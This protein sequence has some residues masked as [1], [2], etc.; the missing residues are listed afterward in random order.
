MD[1]AA[2]ETPVWPPSF[3][4]AYC[5]VNTV[6]QHSEVGDRRFWAILAPVDEPKPLRIDRFRTIR[7]VLAGEVKAHRSNPPPPRSGPPGR[8][9]RGMGMTMLDPLSRSPVSWRSLIVS[10]TAHALRSAS[11]SRLR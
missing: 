2:K 3:L 1:P 8:R 4:L 11:T 6:L 10:R 5:Q 7:V 9:G